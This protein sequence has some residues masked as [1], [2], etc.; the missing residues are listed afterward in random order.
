MDALTLVKMVN[1]VGE[2]FMT[3]FTETAADAEDSVFR[4]P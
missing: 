1:C 2:D 4:C 3:L